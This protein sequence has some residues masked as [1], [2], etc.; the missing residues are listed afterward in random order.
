M[1]KRIASRRPSPAMLVAMIALFV[2]LGGT[3]IAMLGKNSV[4][5]SQV[6][7]NSLK[8][9]DVDEKSFKKVPSATDADTLGGLGASKFVLGTGSQFAFA[10]T[11]PMGLSDGLRFRDGTN[12][13][14]VNCAGQVAPTLSWVNDRNDSGAPGTDIFSDVG[15][16]HISLAD[17]APS[18]LISGGLPDGAHDVEVWTGDDL[19]LSAKIGVS[20]ETSTPYRCLLSVFANVEPNAASGTSSGSRSASSGSRQQASGRGQLERAD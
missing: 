18:T 12:G 2:A 13:L 8:G 17:G 3:S 16:A 15:T 7:K 19:V 4:G 20:K 10:G 9:K 14:I 5:S 11:V 6:K 1:L